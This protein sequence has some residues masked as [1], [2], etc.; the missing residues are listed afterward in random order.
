MAKT[1]QIE[2][3]MRAFHG[4]LHTASRHAQERTENNQRE[5]CNLRE[6]VQRIDSGVQA[7]LGDMAQRVQAVQGCATATAAGLVQQNREQPR[8]EPTA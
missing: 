2:Q 3:D 4:E 1:Q 5:I 7:A 6:Q 8:Q